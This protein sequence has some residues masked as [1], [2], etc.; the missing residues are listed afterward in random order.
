MSEAAKASSQTALVG[1]ITRRGLSLRHAISAEV[2]MAVEFEW[3]PQ[4]YAKTKTQR[5]I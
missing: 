2:E 5:E 4:R 3:S 1:M